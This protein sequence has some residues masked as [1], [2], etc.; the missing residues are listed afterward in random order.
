MEELI[1][2]AKNKDEEAFDEIIL[3]VE[4][5]MY[6]IAKARLKSD[7]DIADAMQETILSCYRNI[8][9]LKDNSVFKSWLIRILINKCNDIYKKQKKNL[10]SLEK[11]DIDIEDKSDNESKL[12]FYMLIRNLNEDEKTILTLYYYFKYTTKEI[13]KILKVNENTVKSKILRAKNKL[14]NE[15]G[16]EDL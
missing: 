10:I 7:E 3:K 13:S 4:K 11:N 2:R 8:H 5:E 12:S 15:Y 1:K 9:K 14:R 16:G 6:L